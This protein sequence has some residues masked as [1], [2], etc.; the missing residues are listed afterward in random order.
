MLKTIAIKA[1]LGVGAIGVVGG[2]AALA[3]APSI[4]ANLAA[5]TTPK[6]APGTAHAAKDR[7]HGTIIKLS[8]TEMTVERQ[9]RDPSTKA[10]TKDDVTFELN[11]KTAVYYFGTKDKHGIDVLKLGQDV[12]VRFVDNNS[13][14]VA[15]GVIILPDHRAGRIV[16]KDADGKS[17][18]IRTR[19]GNLVKV[20]TNDRTRFVEGTRRNRHAGS[21]ADLKVGDRVLVLGQEDS[22][23]VF[24]A[25]VVR[26]ANFDRHVRPNA[27]T[28][29]PGA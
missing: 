3:G 17:F 28:A 20:T 29:T 7:A 13:Q 14:K 2:S 1:L 8:S 15:R 5:A 6:A 22:Q 11:D 21:Y 25:T 27:P 23:H 18:T 4:T 12:G 16:S 24:D 9:R 26:S 10:L 19:D